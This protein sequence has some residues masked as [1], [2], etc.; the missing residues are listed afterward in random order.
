ML[1]IVLILLTT[2]AIAIGRTMLG[3]WFNHLSIYSVI[4]GTALILV[5]TELIHYDRISELA[6]FEILAAWLCLYLGSATTLLLR[7]SAPQTPETLD[8]RWVLR[9]KTALWVFSIVGV[10][11][12]MAQ[13][14]S[15]SNVFGGLGVAVFLE[16]NS[17]YHARVD[18]PDLGL[19]GMSYVGAFAPAACALAGIYTAKLGKLTIAGLLPLTIVAITCVL[20]MGRATL[21]LAAVW[22]IAAFVHT[23]RV[24]FSIKKWQTAIAVALILGVLV[25]GFGLI[26]G[27]RGLSVS[28]YSVSP[29]MERASEAVPLLPPIFFYSTGAVV[30]F[31]DYLSHQDK[32]PSA[33]WGMYTFAPLWRVASHFGMNT[34]VPF[35]EENYYTPYDINVLTYLKNVHSDFGP[36]GVLLFP[37]FLGMLMTWLKLKL[38]ERFSPLLAVLIAHGYLIICFSFI[39]NVMFLGLWYFSLGLGAAAAYYV[40]FDSS[41]RKLSSQP[42]L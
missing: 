23:P 34:A 31:S 17:L 30:G 40:S 3:R 28:D 36:L 25:G 18:Y 1:I 9:L 20:E 2:A 5:Q 42:V 15:V 35:Y 32:N 33:F 38:D 10:I 29:V 21:I 11:G 13:A 22:F 19:A 16:G 8:Q 27:T 7:G 41:R 39:E 12:V 26:N 14:R 24:R 4:W 37:Y 6:W